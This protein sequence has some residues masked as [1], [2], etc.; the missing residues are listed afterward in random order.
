M[1]KRKSL[2]FPHEQTL[3]TVLQWCQRLCVNPTGVKLTHFSRLV[4]SL[5]TAKKLTI[6]T[7]LM[8]SDLK[9][10]LTR[11]HQLYAAPYIL[12]ETFKC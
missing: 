4:G 7:Q 11:Q 1:F 8:L 2:H 3:Q 12:E 6:T 9:Q 10:T 5:L